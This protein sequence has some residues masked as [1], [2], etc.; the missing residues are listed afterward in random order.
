MLYPLWTAKPG[1]GC[2][3]ISLALAARLAAKRDLDV[4]VVV[5]VYS[6]E[7]EALRI[8]REWIRNAEP[9]WNIRSRPT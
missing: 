7:R 5:D 6:S 4:R 2:S 9:T 3:T 1:S 8:E